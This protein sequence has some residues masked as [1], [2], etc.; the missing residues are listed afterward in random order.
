MGI[1]KGVPYRSF[2]TAFDIPFVYI[3]EVNRMARKHP[4]QKKFPRKT[5]FTPINQ[6]FKSVS[7]L[8]GC[9]CF[10]WS[11]N[12]FYDISFLQTKI[13]CKKDDL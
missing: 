9:I 8:S 3:L 2:Q 4:W 5:P 6:E 12:D 7:V 1:S 11:A 13:F 10:R